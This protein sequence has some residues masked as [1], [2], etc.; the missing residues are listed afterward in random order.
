MAS[1]LLL[2]D[3]TEK[4]TLRKSRNEIVFLENWKEVAQNHERWKK[5]R[6]AFS[7]GTV[8]TGQIKKYKLNKN[9]LHPKAN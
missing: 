9:I 4:I 5:R 6:M 1:H 8:G 2:L 7:L 3:S